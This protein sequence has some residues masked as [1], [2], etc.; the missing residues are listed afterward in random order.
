MPRTG[1]PPRIANHGDVLNYRRGCRCPECKQAKYDYSVEH[2]ARLE[3]RTHGL[4]GTYNA[5]C[6]CRMCK[7]V[8]A[9]WRRTPKIA[10]TRHQ[11]NRTWRTKWRAFMDEM[12]K[13][14]CQDCRQ[15]FPPICMDFDHIPERGPKLFAISHAVLSYRQAEKIK[16]EIAKCDL[17]CANCHRIRTW[18]RGQR[19]G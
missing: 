6:R 1:R 3:N 9:N 7:T 19:L 2:P 4:P 15:E 13:G 12:K 14:P 16:I 10:K 11:I 17:V 8:F 18:K 5:G